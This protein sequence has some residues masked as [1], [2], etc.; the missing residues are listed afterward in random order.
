M[1]PFQV[2]DYLANFIEYA[3]ANILK[4]ACGVVVNNSFI[5]CTNIAID[6][7]TFII[8]PIEYL[9]ASKQGDVQFICHSHLTGSSNPTPADIYGC[10]RSKVPWFIYSLVDKTSSINAPTEYKFPFLGRPYYFGTL[11][12]WGLVGDVLLE[13]K[14]I[15]V[16]RPKVTEQDWF[17]YE[18]NLFEKYADDNGFEKVIDKTLNKYDVLLFKAGRTKIPNH[19]GIM[20]NNGTFLHHTANRISSQE[21]Y[22]GYWNKC[23]V[24]LYR[25]RELK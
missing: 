9:K 18:E 25:H 8:D 20:Y 23:T 6:K 2:Q 10:N 14:G 22:G 1:E 12:C 24:A 17:K 19:S 21:I 11:D 13:E 4:E 3:E 7:D 15:K 16:G 5:P